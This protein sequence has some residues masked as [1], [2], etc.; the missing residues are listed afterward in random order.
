MR[1]ARLLALGLLLAAP[2]SVSL[3]APLSAQPRKRDTV[4]DSVRAMLREISRES[5]KIGKAAYDQSRPAAAVSDADMA[6]AYADT[7]APRILARARVARLAQDSALKSYRAV[8]TQ[9]MSLGLG[10]RRVGLEKLLFRGDNVARVEWSRGGGVWITPIGS[11]VVVPM[12][13]DEQDGGDFTDAVSVPY[14]PG[15][16]TL[17]MPSSNFGVVKTDVDDRDLVHPI[18][19][20]AEAYYRYAAGDS[21]T[22]RL[23]GER[24]IRLREL[25]VT[26]RRPQW[27]LFVG[28]F[29][30]D[31]ESGQL[32]RAVYRLAVP[33]EVWDVA[34]E[35]IAYD[36]ARSV[37]VEQA[38]DSIARARLPRDVYERDSIRRAERAAGSS[39]SDDEPP[40]WVKAAF[41][42]AR[43]T[44]DAIT[45]EYGLYGGRFW[46]PRANSA[47]FNAEIGPMRAPFTIDEKFEYA[48]VNGDFSM[49]PVPEART[50]ARDSAAADSIPLDS[51][52][53]VMQ[54]EDGTTVS[55][56]FGSDS[57]GRAKR[58][59]V[60]RARYC[61][62][63]DSTYVR[64]E[65]RFDGALRVAYT[66][67]CDRNTLA[68]SSALPP[69]SAS[70][71][72]LFDLTAR[73]QLLD[74]LGLSLQ[75]AWGPQRPTLRS[76]LDQVR[77]NRV[78]GLSVGLLGEQVL[79][80]GYTAR[81]K[82][83]LGHADLALNGE[84][85]FERSNGRRTVFAT[86]YRRLRATA[87]EWGDPL[88]FGPSLPAILFARDEG[89]YFRALGVEVGDRRV[90]RNGSFEWRLFNEQQRTA[91]DSSVV[92]TWSLGR[93][94]GLGRFRTN[95][96]ASKLSVTGLEVAWAR[97]SGSDPSGLRLVTSL[98]GEGGTG[99]V[100]YGRASAEAQ[101][102]RPVR[103][104]A[105]AL[106]GSVGASV[107][108]LPPQRS[109]FL[110]G[111]R[112]VRGN[113]PGS[114]FG[115]AYWFLRTE[116]GTR[117]G[118]LRPVAFFD[119]GWA[120]SRD[121]F[122]EGRLL[123]GAGAGLSFLD[124][125]FRLD[126]A[127]GLGRGTGWRTDLYFQGPL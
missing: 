8:T 56:S 80:A 5:N 40:G 59:S 93:S 38:R 57:A 39:N 42:P 28:S 6:S 16:E 72:A 82:A 54:G 98:R 9:R 17:W 106:T 61:A 37:F 75:P 23:D 81:A 31:Q 66:M 121:A 60:Y 68:S 12:G 87:P 77:Y 67:P 45:V 51:G 108:D 89:F 33:I 90:Q 127:R 115:N 95:F 100:T 119:A 91:G 13:G 34:S 62:P 27:K 50:A 120:G 97:A 101:V 78:E 71:D 84:V 53:V 14:F 58:D 26:A 22:I 117:F 1:S 85:G 10:V 126:V 48:D 112:T 118:A 103:R 88:S 83:R 114:E 124:G 107:G 92:S 19:R 32:A 55:I 43:G 123:R 113:A 102:S 25:R 47:S 122:G 7:V 111:L 29:W 20:G 125:L 70:T 4:P 74:A 86:A 94:L 35:E 18:A 3:S 104:L 2:L 11:R 24:S 105:L 63:G 52:S 46:L 49:P 41:R 99:T 109:W 73:D 76:G 110:G 69:S 21:I 79:G 30:F 96:D 44:L 36:S 65:S 15:R 116:A 64:T